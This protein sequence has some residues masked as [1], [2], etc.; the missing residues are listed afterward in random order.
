MVPLCYMATTPNKQRLSTQVFFQI[1]TTAL[2]NKVLNRVTTKIAIC[3]VLA[4]DMIYIA[5]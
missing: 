5:A 2:K 1:G 4:I 3:L